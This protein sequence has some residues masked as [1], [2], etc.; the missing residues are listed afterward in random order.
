MVTHP[1]GELSPQEHTNGWAVNKG[2][3]TSYFPNQSTTLSQYIAE[4]CKGQAL[5]RSRGRR[6]YLWALTT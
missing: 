5:S 6:L 2:D 4:H 1:S 3:N